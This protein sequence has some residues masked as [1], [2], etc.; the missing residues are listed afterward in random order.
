MALSANK[1]GQISPTD[2]RNKHLLKRQKTLDDHSDGLGS[3]SSTAAGAS[4]RV[5]L[6]GGGG[7]GGG[8]AHMVI[9]GSSSSTSRLDT[10]LRDRTYNRA[11]SGLGLA[12]RRS[13]QDRARYNAMGGSTRA[14][15]GGFGITMGGQYQG[16]SYM[17]ASPGLFP[18]GPA[19]GSGGFGFDPAYRAG[20][21]AGPLGQ[22]AGKTGAGG[23]HSQ[24]AGATR[25]ISDLFGSI[26]DVVKAVEACQLESSAF[27]IDALAVPAVL[28]V[29]GFVAI[30]R[31]F[32][33]SKLQPTWKQS[34][35]GQR[36]PTLI[37][38]RPFPEGA[39]SPCDATT[40]AQTPKVRCVIHDDQSRQIREVTET[41]LEKFIAVENERCG[42]RILISMPVR[43]EIWSSEVEAEVQI[44]DLPDHAAAGTAG[45]KRVS[46]GHLLGGGRFPQQSQSFLHQSSQFHGGSGGNEHNIT[47]DA[48]PGWVKKVCRGRPV[49]LDRPAETADHC[50]EFFMLPMGAFELAAAAFGGKEA[51]N[52]GVQPDVHMDGD[53][54][55]A[56]NGNGGDHNADVT[57]K[58]DD[59]AM[60]SSANA[61]AADSDIDGADRGAIFHPSDRVKF[62]TARSNLVSYLLAHHERSF[63]NKCAPQWSRMLSTKLA[64]L[65]TK[66]QH[67]MQL[68][69]NLDTTIILAKNAGASVA[70]CS[71]FL[72]VDGSI[73]QNYPTSAARSGSSTY[74]NSSS[75]SSGAVF[76]STAAAPPART[77]ST[78]LAE[79]LVQFGADEQDASLPDPRFLNWR[80]LGEY[81]ESV[82]KAHFFDQT[83]SGGAALARLLKECEASVIFASPKFGGGKSAVITNNGNAASNLENVLQHLRRELSQCG[84][85]GIN[86]T[87]WQ[88]VV[89]KIFQSS[90]HQVLQDSVCYV[91]R[92]LRWFLKLQ[93]HE[94]V[95]WMQTIKSSSEEP[96][97]SRLYSK[98]GDL[99]N[100]RQE[101]R[102]AVFAAYDHAIDQSCHSFQRIVQQMLSAIYNQPATFLAKQHFKQD[103]QADDVEGFGQYVLNY[104]NDHS[105]KFASC[106]PPT[107]KI[108]LKLDSKCA[109]KISKQIV[110]D[111]TKKKKGS[112]YCCVVG[113]NPALVTE[114]IDDLRISSTH[115]AIQVHQGRMVLADMSSNGTFIQRLDGLTSRV[116]K[117]VTSEIC[118]GERIGI[119]TGASLPEDQHIW[120][121]IEEFFERNEADGDVDM[122]V[123]DGGMAMGMNY[124][125]VSMVSVDPN[126]LQVGSARPPN[127][128]EQDRS[129]RL[130]SSIRRVKDEMDVKKK[131]HDVTNKLDRK[132]DTVEVDHYLPIAAQHILQAFLQIKRWVSSHVGLFAHAFLIKPLRNHLLEA[133]SG[134]YLANMLRADSAKDE[135]QLWKQHSAQLQAIELQQRGIHDAS[136]LLLMH[137]RAIM[138]RRDA[139][140]V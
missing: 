74:G 60:L 117:D 103:D 104:I 120:Y 66:H 61:G 11:S 30:A 46:S 16:G 124:N 48:W 108:I 115:F 5:N 18:G 57:P 99:L 73:R 130:R 134:E 72:L 83:L 26:W 127:A 90:T 113:R 97:F 1:R 88:D 136:D 7:L 131:A 89:T 92:R 87:T 139:F 94:I 50:S 9:G 68:D 10:A 2:I 107:K 21:S 29:R 78:T 62:L 121:R 105:S 19:G 67:V 110:V 36:R 53:V 69:R 47:S 82:G 52:A 33:L 77:S 135:E 86:Q 4:G 42:E 133:M 41:E 76:S 84:G 100:Q 114:H 56:A 70:A 14:G 111:L 119:L 79:E 58:R 20:T 3:A 32:G 23:A 81:Y 8:A 59:I 118:I 116:G 17:A 28:G 22:R 37:S 39:I 101:I 132:F 96:W 140:H 54:G 112:G 126:Q 40:A 85:V 38:F 34:R 138:R 128:L 45:R 125:N 106:L 35:L 25:N 24:S 12:V 122:N 15:A 93:K 51:G 31:A 102:K 75:S 13:S 27:A 63:C 43:V 109:L 65:N 129:K 6:L 55:E 64:D 98:H 91:T 95:E 80:N 49:I 137:Q 123:A 44:L 71:S